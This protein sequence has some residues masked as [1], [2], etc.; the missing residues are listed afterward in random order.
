MQKEELDSLIKEN[1]KIM[2]DASSSVASEEKWQDFKKRLGA[3]QQEGRKKPPRLINAQK[4]VIA[5]AVLVMIILL[6]SWFKPS[7]VTGFKNEIF[8]WFNRTGNGDLVISENYNPQY[9]LG[10]YEDISWEEAK[11]IV[12]FELK[13]PH[14]LPTPFSSA[15]QIKV[16]SNDYPKS[17]VTIKFDE[18]ESFLIIKQENILVTE[19]LNTYVPQNMEVQKIKVRDK[20]EVNLI[21]HDSTERIF[22]TE[23][24][25]RFT[26]MTKNIAEEEIIKVIK[27]L[28]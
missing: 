12:L 27:A 14:Y 16:V 24:M 1:L 4:Q 22:W 7:V 19:N 3:Q 8:K 20:L 21:N 5:V 2:I 28:K 6:A 9:Q 13:Y 23:N 11:S 25:I 17:T 18:G 15:P 26:I 10:I